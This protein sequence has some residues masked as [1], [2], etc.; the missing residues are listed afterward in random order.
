M[1]AEGFGE[2]A[3]KPPML[4]GRGR[5]RRGPDRDGAGEVVLP[6]PA[7]VQVNSTLVASGVPRRSTPVG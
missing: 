4:L 2:A 3:E 7:H 6:G 5:Y 1:V